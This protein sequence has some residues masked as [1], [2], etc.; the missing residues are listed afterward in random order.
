MTTRADVAF[1]FRRRG[2]QPVPE[3]L[4]ALPAEPGAEAAS[5]IEVLAADG[6]RTMRLATSSERVTDQVNRLPTLPVRPLLRIQGEPEDSPAQLDLDEALILIPP[7]HAGDPRHRLHR[8]GRP[9]RM[10][11]GPYEVTGDAH[12]PPGT[13]ATGFLLRAGLRFVPLTRARVHLTVDPSVDRRV[14]VAIVN[15]AQAE[16]FR[17]VKPD[18]G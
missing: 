2:S 14:P 16:L 8:P 12:V 5:V 11:V 4:A 6:P 1:L 13:Q 7:A 3:D 10:V 17:D 15:L 9:V 18:I